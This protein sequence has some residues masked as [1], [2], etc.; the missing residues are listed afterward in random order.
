MVITAACRYLAVVCAVKTPIGNIKGGVYASTLPTEDVLEIADAWPELDGLARDVNTCRR[1]SSVNAPAHLAVLGQ[2]LRTRHAHLVDSWL[3]GVT[4]GANLEDTDSRLHLRNRFARE[5]ATLDHA[6]D[7]AYNF[8][9]K[10]WNFHVTGRP[11]QYLKL[12][13]T[14]G[15]QTVA[16]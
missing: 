14:E 7:C 5:R 8:I 4:Y 11:L 9:V 2:A 6:L 16:R 1:N 15:L 3:V 10:A 12:M 13:D